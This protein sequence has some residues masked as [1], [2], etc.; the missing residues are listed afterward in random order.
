MLNKKLISTLWILLGIGAIGFLF[1][2]AKKKG[3]KLCKG[4]NVQVSENAKQVFVDEQ[5]IVIE[6]GEGGGKKGIPIDDID[7]RNIE[8]KLRK[9]P[10]V[11]DAKLYF[12]NN[13]ILQVNLKE[14]DPIARIF[15]RNGN[16][17]FIDSN[18]NYLPTNRNVL[19]R[20]PVFTGFTSD[21]QKLSTPDSLLLEQIKEIAKYIIK[22]S[23][24]MSFVSQINITSNAIFQIVPTVGNS[25]ITIGNAD[26]IN[27]KFNR[28]YSFYHQVLT[29]TGINRYKKID[30]QYSGQVVAS[31]GDDSVYLNRKPSTTDLLNIVVAADSVKTNSKINAKLTQK[32]VVENITK[33]H[34][35]P[36]QILQKKKNKI[37]I[38]TKKPQQK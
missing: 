35:K 18:K 20:V 3:D 2:A 11:T 28:I 25:I 34:Q 13:Q 38:T 32:P 19:A 21:R 12:D 5:G 6:V 37:H 1:I 10:W 23:I 29:K 26:N 4:I 8:I 27:D 9:D 24:W 7:L 17:F 16:S 36:I 14:S 15:T 31:N 33:P 22:D 30:V